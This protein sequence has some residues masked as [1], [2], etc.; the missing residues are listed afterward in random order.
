MAAG[1]GLAV[2]TSIYNGTRQ[3]VYDTGEWSSQMVV[4]QVES[5]DCPQV[6]MLE[7]D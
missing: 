3:T 4:Q 1:Q 2:V 5:D 7:F 6:T